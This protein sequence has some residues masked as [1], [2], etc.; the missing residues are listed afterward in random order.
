MFPEDAEIFWNPVGKKK[1]SKV[2]K[3]LSF[4]FLAN[5]WLHV[6]LVPLLLSTAAL[7]EEW[8]IHTF[9]L[10]ILLRFQVPTF[11]HPLHLSNTSWSSAR[12]SKI[13]SS[14]WIHECLEAQPKDAAAPSSQGRPSGQCW[15][16][17]LLT[18]WNPNVSQCGGGWIPAGSE[19]IQRQR[20]MALP[21][22]GKLSGSELLWS[23]HELWLKDPDILHWII[24][25]CCF[26]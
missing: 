26:L 15:F 20:H 25:Q 1:K 10:G 9:W 24:L 11:C 12:F 18:Y 13:N 21:A 16:S 4:L 23:H 8:N 2:R 5:P 6:Q 17:H 14:L 3:W 7:W 19:A 22:A